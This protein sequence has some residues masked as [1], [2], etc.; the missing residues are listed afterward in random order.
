MS[1]KLGNFDGF[2]PSDQVQKRGGLR[3]SILTEDQTTEP[4]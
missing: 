1:K 2:Y 3:V 4:K